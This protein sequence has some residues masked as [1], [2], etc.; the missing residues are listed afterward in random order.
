MTVEDMLGLS[1]AY[2]TLAD[3]YY[4]YND[5]TQPG[6]MIYIPTDMDTSLGSGIIDIALMLSGNYSEHPGFLMRPLTTKLF[7][8]QEL[9]SSYQDKFKN[10]SQNLIH[11]SIMN[12]FIDDIVQVIRNDV[13]WDQTL[14]RLGQTST[15]NLAS[16]AGQGQNLTGLLPP[17]FMTHSGNV[18]ID[19]STVNGVKRFL[20]EKSA[21]IRAFYNL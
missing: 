5:P 19:T 18:T 11:P 1:D 2:M 6:R 21:N 17:G 3:N 4:V 13:E 9:L 10:L 15:V 12:P 14:P 7:A 16:T 20:S 8:N